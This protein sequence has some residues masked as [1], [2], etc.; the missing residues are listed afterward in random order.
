MV[1][2]HKEI[3]YLSC[4]LSC[5]I[6]FTFAGKLKYDPTNLVLERYHFKA[7]THCQNRNILSGTAFLGS[8]LLFC[9][10][11]YIG[12][13]LTPLF[14]GV[15]HVWLIC[16]TVY[17]LLILAGYGYAAIAP[18]GSNRFH[19]FGVALSLLILPAGLFAGIRLN[20]DSIRWL[21]L[22]PSALIFVFIILAGTTVILQQRYSRSNTS[23]DPYSL[24]SA[25]NAGA[26]AAL[27]GY[28]FLI[29]PLI[30]LFSQSILWMAIYV[31]FFLMMVVSFRISYPP[32]PERPVKASAGCRERSA[33]KPVCKDFFYWSFLSAITSAFLVT[34][35]NITNSEIGSFPLAWMM[36][37]SLYLI[38]FIVSFRPVCK[39][40]DILGR[41]W[42]E[43][44]LFGMILFVIGAG[45]IWIFPGHW[46]VFLTVC[47][48]LHRTLYEQR[49][50]NDRLS[51]FY[52]AVALGG[53]AGGAFVS[54][55][56]P[57]LFSGF[58]EYPLLA[59]LAV[60]ILA[61][62][63]GRQTMVVLFRSSRTIRLA[64][65]IPMMLM[66]GMIIAISI[67]SG[68]PIT[69]SALRNY[70]G[71]TRVI[72]TKLSGQEAYVVRS[73]VSGATVHGV[74]IL[75]QR[76]N[77]AP[78]L[79]YNPASGLGDIFDIIPAGARI[80]AVGLGVGTIGAYTRPE[81]QLDFFELNPQV[82]IL[83]GKWFNFIETTPATTRVFIQ[84][85]RL[86]LQNQ[87]GFYDLIFIDAFNGE[88]IP[89]HLLTLEAL[90][91][92][93]HRLRN[94]GII[95][96]HITNRYYD[97][98]PVLKAA[99]DRLNLHAVSKS[100]EL[101][102]AEA[103]KPVRTDYFAL[104]RNTADLQCLRNVGWIDKNQKNAH[105]KFRVWTD[106]YTT[107]FI[108]LA[109]KWTSLFREQE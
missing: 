33:G 70:Y 75:D 65:A 54:L 98:F 18:A 80:A 34:V 40:S 17:Q 53:A 89:S 44:F 100:T 109:A 107:M 29:E 91:I 26:L 31:L 41:A 85:G 86:A 10:E 28:P 67:S 4:T 22:F 61:R 68:M 43:L 23:G 6:S 73:L 64:R 108:P 8:F 90:E 36:P 103:A 104:G 15:A 95:L 56:A 106:D 46:F 76:G 37:L 7:M 101:M 105:S 25:S 9:L 50:V 52:I 72:E 97:L 47:V 84:D 48:L 11:L 38:S 82:F 51:F 62:R 1:T 74:Q 99:A 78:T 93:L 83:A 55:A 81:D 35:T 21:V 66:A 79:Y 30:G 77:S 94:H 12:R 42:P 14:G 59:I 16:L 5:F 45:R 57:F 32:E 88:G 24:Y 39:I 2:E 71:T 63:H 69:R 13:R 92:Y 19:L 87:Q 96:F 60:V 102:L 58:L 3:D 27:M 49:P 20:H